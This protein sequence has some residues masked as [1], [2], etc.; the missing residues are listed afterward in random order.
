MW[1]DTKASSEQLS[2]HLIK[3]RRVLH[4]NLE[5]DTCVLPLLARGA[6]EHI[7]IPL[8]QTPGDRF[9]DV[10]DEALVVY[11]DYLEVKAAR[12][13]GVIEQGCNTSKSCGGFTPKGGEVLVYVV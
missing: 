2:G 3:L 1:Y 11:P 8:R 10:A 6:F 7:F 4:V 13:L 5:C 12:I 9:S